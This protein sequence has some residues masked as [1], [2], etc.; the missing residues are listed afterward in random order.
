MKDILII[1]D[2]DELRGL[3]ADFMAAEGFSVEQAGTAEEGIAFLDGELA[4]LVLLDLMLPGIDGFTACTSI[5]EHK[6]IPIIMMSARSDDESKLMGYKLGADDYI[7]KPLTI[8]ILTA[9]IRALLR[10]S[11]NL[12]DNEETITYKNIS[13]NVKKRAVFKDGEEC[14]IRGKM[15]DLLLYM[16]K[17]RGRLLEKDELYDAVWKDAFVEQATLNVHVRWLR[18]RLEEE[19]NAPKIIKTVWRKG[20]IFGDDE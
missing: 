20:Y 5:R 4:R 19:P 12:S 3:L 8:P 17:N 2:D 11:D 7:E 9:K 1:E 18:E 14:D 13:I 6:D 16:M 10:R 15:Y